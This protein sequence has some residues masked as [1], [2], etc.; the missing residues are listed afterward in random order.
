MHAESIGKENVKEFIQKRLIKGEKGLHDTIKKNKLCTF[1]N[2]QGKKT[3]SVNVKA[4]ILKADRGV[5]AR[6]LIIWER[7][8]ISLRE[9]LK[10]SLGLIA[11]SLANNDGTRLNL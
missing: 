6:L 10:H 1:S 7:R 4:V 5:F 3:V 9:V 11:W 2:M 8:D